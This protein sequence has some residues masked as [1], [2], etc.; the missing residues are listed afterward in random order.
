MTSCLWIRR[1]HRWA[2]LTLALL[3]AGN[4]AVIPFGKP[5]ALITYAPLL[6]LAFLLAS[7]LYMFFRE[8][9]ATREV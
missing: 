8:P 7:G 3:T 2:G 9:L 4:F 1:S 5:P 6:P